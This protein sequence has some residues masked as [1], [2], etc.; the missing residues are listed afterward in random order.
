MII[1]HLGCLHLGQNED[2]D[3]QNIKAW[4][5]G[6]KALS[7]QPHVSVKLSM[8]S[9]L[10]SDWDKNEK[11][12]QEVKSYVMETITMFGTERCMFA[13]NFPVDYTNGGFTGPSLYS[14]FLEL[15]KDFHQ[16]ERD[17]LFCE[18]ARKVYR[19]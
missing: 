14:K 17:N 12:F 13:S 1:N 10:R 4:R 11:S 2:E 18:T 9:F 7:M 5:E 6:M 15:V 3:Q 19:L 8:L 16:G